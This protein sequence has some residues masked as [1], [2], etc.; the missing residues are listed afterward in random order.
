M[1]RLVNVSGSK[2]ITSFDMPLNNVGVSVLE[3]YLTFSKAL[4][5]HYDE[6]LDIHF[7]TFSYTLDLS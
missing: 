2:V 1:H 4:K 6:I 7:F 5:Y 3:N